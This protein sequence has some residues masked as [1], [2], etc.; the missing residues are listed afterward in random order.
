MADQILNQGAMAVM[1]EARVRPQMAAV[2]ERDFSVPQT[3]LLLAELVDGA[4]I[5]LEVVIATGGWAPR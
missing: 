1:A 2:T 5:S 4:L 3:P